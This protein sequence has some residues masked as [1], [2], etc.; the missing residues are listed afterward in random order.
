MA[1]LQ[2][3]RS[4]Y[5]MLVSHAAELSLKALIAAGGADDERLLVLGHDLQLCL[6]LA[7]KQGLA[8]DLANPKVAAIV[9]AL[10]PPHMAQ[11]FRYPSYLSWSL[12]QPSEALEVLVWLLTRAQRVVNS[13]M[14]M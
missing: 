4:P 1:E 11:A 6:R 10:G 14:K 9:D 5:F 13:G 7:R 8:G 2:E 12:P 3:A